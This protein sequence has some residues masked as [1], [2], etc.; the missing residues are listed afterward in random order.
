MPRVLA[1]CV[2]HQLRPDSG[3][4]GVTG[5]DKRPVTGAVHAG[6]YGLRGDVQASR[7]HHGGLDKAVYAYAQEDARF[8]EEQLGR[9]LPPGWFG[10]NLRVDGLDVNAA[11]IGEVWR[12][13][14][15]VEVEV[16]MPRTPCST[17]ARWVGGAEARGW[18]RRFAQE[19]R[20]GPYLRVRRVGAIRAG[21]PIEVLS[22]PE[23]APSI[24]DV[25]RAPG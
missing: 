23:G 10:E 4:V 7:K 18:V 5:I 11:R 25:F 22:V 17:F 2:V 3:F 15:T 16:T 12:I 9:E 13:G 20:L 19:R 14:E 24:R 1:V 8:W 21:D 6:R